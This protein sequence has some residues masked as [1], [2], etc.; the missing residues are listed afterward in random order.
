M[1]TLIIF[2]F[3][4]LA[5]FV[6]GVTLKVDGE[7]NYSWHSL[8]SVPKL[9]QPKLKIIDLSHNNLSELTSD[10]FPQMDNLNMLKI[11]FNNI[12]YVDINTFNSTKNLQCL[13]LS[14]NLLYDISLTFLMHVYNLKYL[15]ISHNKFTVL[16]LSTVFVSLVNLENIRLSAEKLQN[17]EL[18]STSSVWLKNIFRGLNKLIEYEYDKTDEV[19]I[20]LKN[21]HNI[22][23]TKTSTIAFAIYQIR[24]NHTYHSLSLIQMNLTWNDLQ[25]VILRSDIK[26]LNLFNLTITGKISNYLNLNQTLPLNA[27]SLDSVA[28]VDYFFSQSLFYSFFLHIKTKQLTLANAPLVHMTCPK[29]PSMFQYLDFSHNAF[30]EHVFS[31]QGNNDCKMFPV[32]DTLILKGNKLMR[33]HQLSFSTKYMKVLKHL[34]ASS[35][36]LMYEYERCEWP[37]SLIHLNLSSNNLSN[38]VFKCLPINIQILDLQFNQ[39]TSIPKDMVFLKDLKEINLSSNRMFNIP[40]CTHFQSVEF[41]FLSSN[42]LK[43][44]SFNFLSSCQMLKQLDVSSNPFFCDCNLRRFSQMVSKSRI[45]LLGW[46]DL[47]SCSEPEAFNGTLL[48]DFHMFEI[49]CNLALLLT[50]I[51]IPLIVIVISIAVLCMHFDAPWYLRMMWQWT[52]TKQR[53]KTKQLLETRRDLVYNA[54]VSYSQDDSS[55]VKEYLLPNLEEMGTLKICYHERNFI[56][57]KSITENIITCIEKSYKSIFVLS[58]NF[59]SSEWCHYELYFAQHQLL[60]EG[61]ENLI[62]I[63]LE[64]IHQHMIPSKYYKLKDLMARKTYM[65]WPQDKNKHKLFWDILRSSIEINLPEIKDVQ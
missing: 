51:L 15:N 52:Q 58:T 16:T 49:S 64:P 45:T 32:L 9:F 43:T 25:Y 8:N 62:L 2:A 31:S 27:F 7:A 36:M 30:S 53:A 57:G 29:T 23:I 21:I 47:Y 41:L 40:D 60:S 59:I 35:N 54:F 22:N 1:Y 50:A 63:L 28:M 11:S 18:K 26:Y 46:P 3:E 65:E 12:K 39:I 38:L 13:D 44:S 14:Y 6:S 24:K 17:H 20:M 55:W 61:S 19:E 48:E 42:V 10:S 33:L 5:I 37:E 34:D 56:A 4:Q